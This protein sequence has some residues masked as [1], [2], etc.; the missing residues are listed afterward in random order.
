MRVQA[1]VKAR[2]E[3]ALYALGDELSVDLGKSPSLTTM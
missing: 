3:W 1:A 2:S